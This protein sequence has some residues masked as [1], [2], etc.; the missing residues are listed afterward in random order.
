LGAGLARSGGNI[1]TGLGAAGGSTP[2]S[3]ASGGT[4]GG[5]SGAGTPKV[6]SS[7]FQRS[8]FPG[9]GM[10]NFVDRKRR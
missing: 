9:S 5:G 2:A 1:E 10:G 7:E 8:D 4:L 6:S 3:E